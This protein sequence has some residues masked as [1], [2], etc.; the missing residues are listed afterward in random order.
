MPTNRTRRPRS[1][2]ADAVTVEAAEAWQIGD[3]HTLNRLLGIGPWEISPFY[4]DREH[5][6]DTASL[7]RAQEL[8]QALI[9]AA[10]PPGRFDRHGR[11]LGP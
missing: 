10:G 6:G 11:P 9:E 1:R 3:F 5:G 7:P 8:R 4:A 2:A